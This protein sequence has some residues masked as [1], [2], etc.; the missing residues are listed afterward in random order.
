MSEKIGPI[1]C[2]R[3]IFSCKKKSSNE[4]IDKIFN[5]LISIIKENKKLKNY[6]EII[7]EQENQIFNT[8][9]FLYLSLKDFLIYIFEF[10]DLENYI[11]ITAII[12]L[13][14]FCDLGSI[15]LTEFN[16]HKLLFTSILLS[17]K[18]NEDFYYDNYYYSKI[19]GI[20][21]IE[22]NKLEY[23]FIKRLD[24]NL[25]INKNTYEK[26]KNYVFQF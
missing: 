7:I 6:K 22:L 16:I 23:E 20:T 19:M 8:N 13:E 11:L 17:I 25:F 9:D 3:K 2:P 4:L 10:S 1:E 15:I 14:R 21:N 12:Y 26:Y 18:N 5:F 24:F